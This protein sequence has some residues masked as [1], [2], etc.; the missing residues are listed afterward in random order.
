MRTS[1]RYRT[2]DVSG[3]QVSMS[4]IRVAYINEAVTSV[5]CGPS[6]RR[7]RSSDGTN[8]TTP[9]TRTKFGERAFSV[10]RPSI[11]NSLPKHIRS[12]TN[13]H[14][15]KRRLKTYLFQI[16]FSAPY[17]FYWVCNAWPFRLGVGRAINNFNNNNYY[18]QPGHR[19]GRYRLSACHWKSHH[20]EH[21][22][23]PR[24]RLPLSAT[25][26]FNST[27]QCGRTVAVLGTFSHIIPEDEMKLRG[28]AF[29]LVFNLVF[30]HLDLYWRTQRGLRV[31]K[32]PLNF[33]IF[34]ELC[35]CKIYCPHSAPIL[36]KFQI[37]YRKTLKIVC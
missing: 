16:H 22:W 31:F 3:T 26:R 6:Q 12:A 23:P 4:G 18:K 27:L 17:V 14:C 25:L 30:S 11:W 35:V 10:A 34:F 15:F 8:Y 5:I 7:L 9:S 29:V 20:T 36:I 13:K 2:A 32:A 24:E 37:L 19:Q 28:P 33:Q 21:R 1:I